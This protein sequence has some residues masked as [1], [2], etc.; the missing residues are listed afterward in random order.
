MPEDKNIPLLT[1]LI[2]RGDVDDD[3]TRKIDSTELS[4]KETVIR[5]DSTDL[6]IEDVTEAIDSTELTAALL[7][8]DEPD[9]TQMRAY[10]NVEESVE[11]ESSSVDFLVEADQLPET[12]ELADLGTGTETQEALN[13]E[14]EETIQRIIDK[15]MDQA[16]HEIRLA[17]Q[18]RKR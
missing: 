1:D 2:E 18:L 16:M 10:D 7:E 8:D 5:P 4:G 3:S 12:I 15:H 11:T 9:R 17:L 13:S 14:L 6:V